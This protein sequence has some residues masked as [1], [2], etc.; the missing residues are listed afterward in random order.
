MIIARDVIFIFFPNFFS[1]GVPQLWQSQFQLL[2]ISAPKFTPS[3]FADLRLPSTFKYFQKGSA[4]NSWE[5]LQT[6]PIAQIR[7]IIVPVHQLKK[8]PKYSFQGLSSTA[9]KKLQTKPFAS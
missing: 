2:R 9:D 7:L 4:K 6:P 8:L 5:L 3:K 1:P